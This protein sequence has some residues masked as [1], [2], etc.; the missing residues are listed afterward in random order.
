MTAERLTL[1][2]LPARRAAR[3]VRVVGG[4]RGVRFASLGLAAG[5]GIELEQREPA[6][7]ARVGATTLALEPKLGAQVLVELV[8][9]R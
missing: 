8:D 7:V 5:V 6:L 2:Q 4:P 1:A 9:P 3:V